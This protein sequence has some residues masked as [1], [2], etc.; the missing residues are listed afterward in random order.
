MDGSVPASGH[1]AGWPV[2]PGP[3][4]AFPMP[5]PASASLPWLQQPPG[6]G[7]QFPT[8]LLHP[9]MGTWP[10]PGYMQ[11][12]AFN[13][14]AQPSHPS[15]APPGLTAPPLNPPTSN[16]Q[17][18][19]GGLGSS[20]PAH[21]PAYAMDMGHSAQPMVL[22]PLDT[23]DV[24]SAAGGDK[25][26]DSQ[27]EDALSGDKDVHSYN[28]RARETFNKLSVLFPDNFYVDSKTLPYWEVKQ[29]STDFPHLIVDPDLSHTWL[30]PP[31]CDTDTIG[32]WK[33]SPKFP[34][35]L[36]N[37][38]PSAEL[39]LPKRP[40]DIH[41]RDTLLKDFLEARKISSLNL[42]TDAF[43]PCNFD[44]ESSPLSQV[45]AFLRSTLLDSY[46]SDEL[47]AILLHLVS[48]IKNELAPRSPDVDLT[49]LD[50]LG[51]VI[52]LAAQSNARGQASLV[53]AVTYNKVS[54]RDLVLD[55]FEAPAGSKNV[56]RGTSIV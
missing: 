51:D 48:M 6:F 12:L 45:D 40:T 32:Y 4:Q 24:R 22:K 10:Q 26:D 47:L 52:R 46:V 20:A 16:W 55:K 49:T 37:V 25:E 41:I 21:N 27:C 44:V 18:S 38:N 19:Q 1:H 36:P 11:P 13:N 29:P 33:P 35:K 5:T 23:P 14:G 9:M 50:L 17:H 31:K 43:Q 34:P 56:L 39:P 7:Y 53:A 42:D 2:H 3:A 30:D 28:M 15:F 8:P 54:L